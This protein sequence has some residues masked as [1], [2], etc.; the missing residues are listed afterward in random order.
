MSGTKSAIGRHL[1]EAHAI[2][3]K[4]DKTTQVCLWEKCRKQMRGESIPRHILAVHMRDKVLCPGCGL[5]FSR[6]DSMQ[7]H[8]K[9]CLVKG[10]DA[11]DAC[12]WES[13]LAYHRSRSV[14]SRSI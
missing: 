4:A 14:L 2:R 6:T 13:D 9:T 10:E 1:Q 11:S 5:H 12:K 8:L 7:R 3:L